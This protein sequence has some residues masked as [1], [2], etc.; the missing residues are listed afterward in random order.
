[1]TLD[2]EHVTTNNKTN[3]TVYI[4]AGSYVK[5]TL[6]FGETHLG[7][8]NEIIEADSKYGKADRYQ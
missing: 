3:A 2:P 8:K 1:M 6:D 4:K 7:G 5:I